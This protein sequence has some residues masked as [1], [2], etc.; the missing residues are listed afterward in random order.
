LLLLPLVRCCC[1]RRQGQMSLTGRRKSPRSAAVSVAT[2]QRTRAWWQLRP[3]W[4]ERGEWRWGWHEGGWAQT[5]LPLVLLALPL[6]P[7][8]VSCRTRSSPA[9]RG[10]GT[11]APLHTRSL[12]AL[13]GFAVHETTWS[14]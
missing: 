13:K 7:P 5:V 9:E 6:L 3:G 12:L 2:R 8:V 14:R 10:R 1:N 4:G 11:S